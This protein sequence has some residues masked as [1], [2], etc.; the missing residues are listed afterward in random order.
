[1]VKCWHK[2]PREAED[3]PSL[4]IFETLSNLLWVTYSE[5]AVRLDD[6]QGPFPTSVI[7]CIFHNF[8]G[9]LMI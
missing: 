2:L 5:Q 3:P 1:M 6:L 7:L 8:L 9:A 4:E